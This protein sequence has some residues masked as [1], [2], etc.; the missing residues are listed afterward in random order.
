MT[1]NFV[2]PVTLYQSVGISTVQLFLARETGHHSLPLVERQ[3]KNGD[4][5]PRDQMGNE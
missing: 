5:E 4:R 2:S 1:V 3:H